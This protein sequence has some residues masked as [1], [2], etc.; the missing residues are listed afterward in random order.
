MNST[1]MRRILKNSAY[2]YV[3]LLMSQGLRFVYVFVIA[4][5]LG[6]ELYG[7][8]AFGNAWY[9]MFLPLTGLGLGIYLS[10]KVGKNQ[11]KAS[12]RSVP[13]VASIRFIAVTLVASVCLIVGLHN[14]DTTQVSIIIVI[15][16][17]ALL[18]K[19]MVLWSTQMFQAY[20]KTI[21]VFKL[22]RLFKP[23]EVML[24]LL[25]AFLTK[26]VLL[27]AAV[28]ATAMVFQG[29]VGVI[30]VNKRLVKVHLTWRPKIM[31]AIV[32]K[33][34][35]LGIAVALGQFLYQGPVVML[36]QE[37]ITLAQ[38]G[39]FSLAIQ[40]FV[41]FLSI[42]SSI[43]T[44]ALP[45][46]SRSA[47]N[48]PQKLK[49]Y[50]RYSI[51]LGV[52]FGCIAALVVSGFAQPVIVLLFTDKF[53]TAG[54]ALSVLMWALV[55]AIVHNMLNST[56]AA[57]EHNKSVFMINSV[58]AIALVASIVYFTQYEVIQGAAVAVILGFSGAALTSMVYLTF[59]G[60]LDISRGIILP[61]S[62]TSLVFL[63]S[64]YLNTMLNPFW[65]IL[66]GSLLTV[67]L[68]FILLVTHS[69]KGALFNK[70]FKRQ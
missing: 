39:N 55:P 30:W 27:I 25:V 34:L 10:Q 17:F 6:A 44:A 24:G 29:I 37:G 41:V 8:L 36:K 53:A 5:L 50:S 69:E 43:R 60:V 64:R 49:D 2:L 32:W 58:G 14:A 67:A 48:S 16:T 21:H 61:I 20:E 4:R 7:L 51:I 15:Y 22:E 47:L 9:L 11:L 45:A 26:D 28:H 54:E 19:A 70:I 38:I 57:L 13:L 12:K 52:V 63:S 35:P 1:G 40:L 59:K 66:I 46:L 31:L 56:Q 23:A 33:L 62:I 42:F 68:A 18:G 65:V 3:T